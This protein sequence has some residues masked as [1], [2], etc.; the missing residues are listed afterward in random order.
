MVGSDSEQRLRCGRPFGVLDRG[1][2]EGSERRQSPE[3]KLRTFSLVSPLL[4]YLM[5]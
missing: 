5:P 2:M 4:P 1:A 3:F